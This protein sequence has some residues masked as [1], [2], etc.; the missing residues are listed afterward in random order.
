MQNKKACFLAYFLSLIA[1]KELNFFKNFFLKR[2]LLIYNL[3]YKNQL[4][5]MIDQSKG[6]LN[7]LKFRLKISSK[8]LITETWA[9]L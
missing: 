8:K 6:N 5:E 4:W 7:I 9:M 1:G 3:I 2:H